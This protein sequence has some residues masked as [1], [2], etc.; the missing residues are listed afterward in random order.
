MIEYKVSRY[1]NGDLSVEASGRCTVDEMNAAIAT[2]FESFDIGYVHPPKRK[3]KA[4]GLIIT[5]YTY[6][7]FEASKKIPT[8]QE[9]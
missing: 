8:T 3:M 7:T 5:N 9:G 6:A 1:F 2:D 4:A